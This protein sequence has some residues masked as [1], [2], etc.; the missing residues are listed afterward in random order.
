MASSSRNIEI[1]A[2]IKSLENL[3]VK[4][5]ELSQS[6]GVVLNQED[7]FFSVPHGRLKLRIEVTKCS[8]IKDF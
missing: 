6:A 5:K 2:K 8:N 3:I 7:T 1:K 4:A